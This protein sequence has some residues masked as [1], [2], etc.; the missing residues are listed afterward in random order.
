[1]AQR[2]ETRRDFLALRAEIRMGIQG[3]REDLRV[4]FRDLR[5]EVHADFQNPRAEVR[6]DS[7]HIRG[8]LAGLRK[9]IQALTVRMAHI[10]GFLLGYFAARGPSTATTTPERP[11]RQPPSLELTQPTTRLTH[12][13]PGSTGRATV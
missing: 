5:Q 12:T 8:D 9:D 4:G 10:E 3:L 6:S 2:Y 7:A 1:M 13:V 11:R